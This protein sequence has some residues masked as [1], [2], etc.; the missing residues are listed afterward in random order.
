MLDLQMLL[1]VLLDP[2]ALSAEVAGV[3]LEVLE[4]V[5]LVELLVGGEGLVAP[6]TLGLDLDAVGLGHVHRVEVAAVE[7]LAAEV[8]R[9]PLDK[10]HNDVKDGSK[11]R[12]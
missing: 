8:A 1:E 4:G 12:V 10:K 11:K 3:G 5:V 7:V 6:R 2:E 9:E